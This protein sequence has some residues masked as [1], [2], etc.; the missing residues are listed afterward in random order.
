MIRFY[1]TPKSSSYLRLQSD[2]QPVTLPHLA[3]DAL[4]A[5]IDLAIIREHI[6]RGGLGAMNCF[7]NHHCTN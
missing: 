5:S 6:N 2:F 7:A 4:A 1:P 3:I